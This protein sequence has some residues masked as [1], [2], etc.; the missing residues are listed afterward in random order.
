[1]VYFLFEWI[2]ISFLG[3]LSDNTNGTNVVS[4]NRSVE[5]GWRE[6]EAFMGISLT[7]SSSLLLTTNTPIAT[8]SESR[9]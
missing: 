2:N 6:V 7:S 8:F 3:Y 5:L 1:M 9:R 4:I